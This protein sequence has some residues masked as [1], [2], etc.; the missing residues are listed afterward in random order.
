MCTRGKE[1][2][3]LPMKLNQNGG[4]KKTKFLELLGCLMLCLEARGIPFSSCVLAQDEMPL[5]G[6]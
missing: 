2:E 5:K 4:K 3:E 6:R 1:T